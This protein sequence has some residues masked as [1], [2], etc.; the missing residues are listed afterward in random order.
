[1]TNPLLSERLTLKQDQTRWNARFS[2]R[3]NDAPT[4]PGFVL[5]RV[6]ALNT[7]SVLDIASGDGAAALYLASKGFAVTATDISDVALTRL[8]DFANMRDQRVNCIRDD[9]DAPQHL[10]HLGPFDNLV[11]T[12]FKP[13]ATYWPLFVS[14]LKPGGKLLLSTFNMMHHTENG[15]SQRFCLAPNALVG[16]SD[17]LTVEHHA[18]VLRGG[19]YMD[20]YLFKKQNP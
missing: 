20:D 6:N 12:H 4:P 3:S 11:M 10:Q 2:M 9:L 14:L 5:E 1:M 15:F 17:Q 18:S 16:I 19:D 7:G 13:Q 8:T